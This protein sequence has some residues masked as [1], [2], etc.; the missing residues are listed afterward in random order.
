M[1]LGSS[2]LR[3]PTGVKRVV[4]MRCDGDDVDDRCRYDDAGHADESCKVCEL[5][6]KCNYPGSA[7]E[8]LF[9][10]SFV[11]QWFNIYFK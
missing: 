9:N 11:L 7:N 1:S 5:L 2:N 8:C 3:A 4:Y 10:A 6:V